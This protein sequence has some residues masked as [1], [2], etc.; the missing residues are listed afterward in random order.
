MEDLLKPV[1]TERNLSIRPSIQDDTPYS[2]KISLGAAFSPDEVLRVLKG[3]PDINEIKDIL[4]FLQETKP[5][6]FNVKAPSAIAAQILQVLVGQTVPDFW[7]QLRDDK[8]L[9]TTKRTLLDC[10]RSTSGLG[11]VLS[12]LKALTT[13]VKNNPKTGDGAVSPEQLRILIE[14]TEGLL[15]GD[16]VISRVWIESDASSGTPTRRTILWREFTS[17]IATSRLP[18]AVAE[19]EDIVRESSGKLDGTWIAKGSEYTKWMG[20]NIA[21]MISSADFNESGAWIAATGICSKALLFG[22]TGEL[23]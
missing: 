18:A 19:A 6:S 5:D 22:Y 23:Q 8:S 7:S 17:I 2:R 12:R 9:K 4:K 11:A 15:N 13:A 14:L 20:R 21:H 1:K 10:L 3:G 16:L